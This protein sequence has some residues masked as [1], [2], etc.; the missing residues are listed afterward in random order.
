MK[1]AIHNIEKNV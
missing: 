1:I